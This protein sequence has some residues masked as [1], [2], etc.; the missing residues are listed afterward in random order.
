MIDRVVVH[1]SSGNGGNGIVSGRHEKYVPRGGPD[2]GNGGNGG[3]VVMI[4]ERNM[5]SLARYHG[6][7]RFVAGNGGNGSGGK[8]HGTKG[9]DITVTVPVGT[10]IW[11][12][13]TESR[14]LADLDKDGESVVVASGGR[15]G[16]GN[17]AF[18]SSTNQYPLLSEQGEAGAS[19]ELRLE[20]KILAD[21]GLIGVP[22]AGKSSLLAAISRARPKIAGYPFTT[23]EP[24]LGVVEHKGGSFVVADVPGLVEGAH[25]GVGLGDDF[26]RH[27]ERTRLLVHVVDGSIDDPVAEQEK[28]DRE[29]L[30]FDPKLGQRPQIVAL[31]KIDLEEVGANADVLA[32]ALGV[33]GGRVVQISAL[34]GQGVSVLLDEVLEGLDRLR[35]AEAP[36]VEAETRSS[37]PPVLR[38]RP[39]DEAI[40]IRKS[41]GT[42]IV[43]MPS[44]ARIAAMVDADNWDAKLQFYAYL[45]KTGVVEALEEAGVVPGSTVR[46]D[47][48]EWEWV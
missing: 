21:V 16:R 23:L 6:R 22:N 44:V 26:L 42:F 14:M 5:S 13:G 35:Q 25:Q 1:V 47:K 36:N 46:I 11:E 19:L 27:I 34:T 4:A 24:G 33:R 29:L 8:K 2:G 40:T 32:E 20:L 30:M 37:R 3:N 45:R 38:P 10:E 18:V 43:D 31:N 15:G 39:V 9:R 48:M 28:I 17:P 41:K 7:R 12:E